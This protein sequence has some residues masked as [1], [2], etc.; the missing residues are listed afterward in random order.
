M[1]EI[2]QKF[3]RLRFPICRDGFDAVI[4]MQY[5]RCVEWSGKSVYM[6]VV[7]Q[8]GTKQQSFRRCLKD[9]VL[10]FARIVSTLKLSSSTLDV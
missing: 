3:E 2:S 1:T 4:D 9:C 10:R 5:V 6:P 8:S 7:S